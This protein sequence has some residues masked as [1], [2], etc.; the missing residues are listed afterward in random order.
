MKKHF[1]TLSL[2]TLITFGFVACSGEAETDAEGD[3][4]TSEQVVEEEEEPEIEEEQEESPFGNM[5]GLIGNWTVDAATAGVQMDLSFGEDGSF[6]QKMGTV[7]GEGTWEVI[8]DEHINIVTQNT[9]G[10]KCKI[11][12]LTETSFNLIW[13]T[14][15]ANPKTIP[16]QRAD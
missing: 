10:S 4:N 7:N 8:D 1:L 14:E 5:E 12:D 15:S 13:N 11:T 3:E 2:L 16:M 9:R 6:T